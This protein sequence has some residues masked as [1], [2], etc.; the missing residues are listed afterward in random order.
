MIGGKKPSKA[1]LT[2]F[3]TNNCLNILITNRIKF[4][5]YNIQKTQHNQVFTISGRYKTNGCE[6]RSDKY[7]YTARSKVDPELRDN[8]CSELVSIINLSGGSVKVL[9][10]NILIIK[11]VLYVDRYFSCN[12]F[13]VHSKINF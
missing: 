12:L 7:L 4:K 9:R 11:N 2:D 6:L 1:K 3:Q 10:I 8:Q 5:T 13:H